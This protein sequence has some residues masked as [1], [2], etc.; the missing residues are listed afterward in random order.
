MYKFLLPVLLC[1]QLATAQTLTVAWRNKPPLQYLENGEEKGLL[2]ERARL[3]FAEAKLPAHFVEEPAKRIWSHF[4]DGTPNYCSLGWYH[5]PEREKIAQYS[6][7]FHSDPPH[8]ILVSPFAKSKIHRHKTLISLLADPELTL[9]LVDNVSYGPELDAQIKTARNRVEHS[10]A[11]PMIMARM[12]T[13]NRADY[14]FID[15]DD[16]DYLSAKD[17]GMQALSR[18]QLSDMPKGL[19]RYIVCSKDVSPETMHSINSALA[20]VLASQKK[21]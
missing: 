13:A 4:A 17:G 21:H 6:A 10:S 8:I 19:N 12:L 14:M 20:H 3:V 7:V 1:A 2:L 15:A 9:G 11:A 5:L 18:L 16:W